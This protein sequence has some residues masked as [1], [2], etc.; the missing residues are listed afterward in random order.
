MQTKGSETQLCDRADDPGQPGASWA[1]PFTRLPPAP[2]GPTP[3]APGF[4]ID[5]DHKDPGLSSKMLRQSHRAAKHT[6]SP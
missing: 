1:Q 5:V 6:T 2:P 4:L 3:P